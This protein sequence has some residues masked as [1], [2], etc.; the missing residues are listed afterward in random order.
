MIKFI[1]PRIAV[2]N[3]ADGR[4]ESLMA[5]NGIAAALNVAN[6][7]DMPAYGAVKGRFAGLIPGP[8]NTLQMIDEAVEVAKTL[9]RLHKKLLIFCHSG[10]DRSPLVA[11]AVLCE[12]ERF[13]F[14]KAWQIV[15]EKLGD[16]VQFEMSEIEEILVNAFQGWHKQCGFGQKTVSIVMPCFERP[17]VTKRCLLSIRKNTEYRPYEIIAINDGSTNN[18][19]LNEILYQYCDIIIPHDENLGVATSR[20][21][22]NDVANGDIICQIDNDVVFFNNWLIPLVERVLKSEQVAIV[23]PM[24]AS[25]IHYFSKLVDQIR[26]EGWYEV[27]EVGCACMVYKKELIDEIGNFDTDLYN[28][29]EDKDFCYRITRKRKEEGSAM[30]KIVV[31]PRVTVYHDGY[32]D[33]DT[34]DWTDVGHAENTRSMGALQKHDKI[35]KSMKVIYDK[36][37]IRHNDMARYEGGEIS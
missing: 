11:A 25:H 18:E 22:G 10:A 29:W 15:R 28:L 6:D 8:G 32:V 9:L 5:F 27:E 1:S 21:E 36:W 16:Q 20:A 33:A 13:S 14:D 17:E 37:G 7:L 31:D 2:G 34:G 35:Y 23:S 19:E 4:N 3:S 24:Y 26:P 12:L 30:S